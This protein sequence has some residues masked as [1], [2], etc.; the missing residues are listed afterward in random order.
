MRSARRAV[1]GRTRRC[2]APRAPGTPCIHVPDAQPAPRS[3]ARRSR[4]CDLAARPA[5][6]GRH[7]TQRPPLEAPEGRWA[8]SHRGPWRRTDRATGGMGRHRGCARGDPPGRGGG[9]AQ[10]VGLGLGARPCCSQHRPARVPSRRGRPVDRR[11]A[12]RP[13]GRRAESTRVHRRV[14]SRSRPVRAGLGASFRTRP[15][16]SSSV[17]GERLQTAHARARRAGQRSGSARSLRAASSALARR[18]RCGSRPS[19]PSAAHA[20]PPWRRRQSATKAEIAVAHSANASH[21]TE[22]P[23]GTTTTSSRSPSAARCAS[24]RWSYGR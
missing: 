21:V 4:P 11:A 22:C 12:P 19:D 24:S 14:E 16:A 7:D 5:S 18:S 17:P 3:H 2:S 23:P 9:G 20:T 15:R 1:G 8:G 13:R 6:D 10:R